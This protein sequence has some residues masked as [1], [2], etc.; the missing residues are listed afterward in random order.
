MKAGS[1]ELVSYASPIGPSIGGGEVP[2]IAELIIRRN[3]IIITSSC[4]LR[5]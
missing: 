4:Y 5:G 2:R 1:Q 3:N